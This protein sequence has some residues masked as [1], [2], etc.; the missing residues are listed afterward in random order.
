M[1]QLHVLF[2]CLLLSFSCAVFADDKARKERELNQLNRKIQQLRQT[3]EV[4][5][6]S[7]SSYTHQLRAI[8]KQIGEVS[9]QIR[10]SNQAVKNKQK[11]LDRLQSD[12][13]SILKEISMHN[14]QLS[15][16]L[17]AAYTL[18]QQERVK[19]FFS[20]QNPMNLQR[21]FTYYE[22]FSN[23][24]LKQIAASQ[25]NYER[26]IENEHKT[27]A[28][29]LEL[30]KVLKQ[31]Q[32]QKSSLRS[33]QSQRENILAKLEKQLK[34]QGKHL[35]QLEDDA[36]ELKS[37]IQ[38]VTEI[39]AE[40]SSD[41]GSTQNF[42]KLHGKL[43]W[44]VKGKVQNLYGQ[45]KPPSNLRWQ[46]VII[47][48]SPGN[49]VRAVAHG[50]VAFSDW[51]RGMGNLVIIDHGNGYLSLYGHNE[52]LFKSPGEW[53]V[54]GDIIGSIGNSGGQSEPGLY[55]EIRK[56]GRPQNP[57]RWC[58]TSNWFSYI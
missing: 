6:S 24:R 29:K 51:L 54:A 44:P 31:Q 47:N 58:K 8:E 41:S 33:D 43:S 10:I 4:K 52:S 26:L 9:R 12:Q 50:R 49:N 38:S 46:G 48:A 34:N 20:Q 17:H 28:A 2:M 15:Q 57:A 25:L 11:L 22:Y 30:E 5:E 19:L 53:V 32:Q 21:N 42:S 3:I 35:S 13:K 37:L 1:G 40:N 55:F 36:K 16:Q 14:A 56:K 27:L 18:G 23:Y 7:K 39:M 45:H